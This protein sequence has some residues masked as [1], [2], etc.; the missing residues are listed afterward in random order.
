[1]ECSQIK[2]GKPWKTIRNVLTE[3]I[4]FDRINRFHLCQKMISNRN[5][6]NGKIYKVIFNLYKFTK[7]CIQSNNRLSEMFE[8]NVGVRQ[9]ENLSPLLFSLYLYDQ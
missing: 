8:C 5:M 9:G 2:T 6:I 1:M 7:T 4:A 3:D